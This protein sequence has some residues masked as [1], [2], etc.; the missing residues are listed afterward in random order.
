M[1]LLWFWVAAAVMVGVVGVVLG[2]ALRHGRQET[3]AATQNQSRPM[4][5]PCLGPDV[6]AK[7]GMQKAQLG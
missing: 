7:R 6:A 1:G 2:Q 5:P 3:L 4:K